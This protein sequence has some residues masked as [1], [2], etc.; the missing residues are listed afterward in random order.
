MT[1][2]RIRRRL[3]DEHGSVAAELVVALPAV[4]LVLAACLGGV[5]VGMQAM[6]AQD[7]AAAAARSLARGE[8]VAAAAARASA[9]APGSSVSV[10][11]RDGLVCV[12]A[13]APAAL[14]VLPVA[15]SATACALE[16]AL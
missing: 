6:A 5:R 2:Q 9:I 10:R 15:P 11:R 4:I 12:S 8:N 13:T 3:R 14:P 16:G 7:A 1:R